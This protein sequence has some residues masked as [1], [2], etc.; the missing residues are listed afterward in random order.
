MNDLGKIGV[1]AAIMGVILLVG[2]ALSPAPSTDQQAVVSTTTIVAQPT[3]EML[4]PVYSEKGVFSDDTI[5]IAFDAAFAGD[6]AESRLQFW[7]ENVSDDAITVLWDRC[8]LQLPSGETVKVLNEESLD[9]FLPLGRMISIAPGGSLR[10]AVIPI[11]EISS[12]GEGGWSL[13]SGVLDAGTFTFVLAVERGIP[14][15]PGREELR[16]RLEASGCEGMAKAIEWELAKRLL[17]RREIVYY[18]FRFV[19]R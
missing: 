15:G 9:D 19:I 5:R 12:D 4:D 7:L 2:L 1:I 18:T 16:R 10:D 6:E 8:S 3:L 13:T 14:T 17:S 11:T